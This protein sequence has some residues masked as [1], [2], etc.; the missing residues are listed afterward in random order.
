MNEPG[1]KLASESAFPAVQRDIF[2]LVSGLEC[3]PVWRH[4]RSRPRTFH[5]EANGGHVS[6]VF[7]FSGFL[8]LQ[9]LSL[10]FQS[11]DTRQ[12]GLRG[13]KKH[14][15]RKISGRS[16]RLQEERKLIGNTT[17]LTGYQ[18]WT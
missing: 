13:R 5:N 14:L 11:S 17:E 8:G 2:G 18:L 7:W 3:L 6:Q 16:E 9:T 10:L 4:F 15:Y 1:R 12:A